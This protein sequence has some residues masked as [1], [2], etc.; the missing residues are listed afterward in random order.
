MLQK[1]IKLIAIVI[2]YI[3]SLRFLLYFIKLLS[4]YTINCLYGQE[5]VNVGENTKFAT[6]VIIRSPKRIFIGSNCYF[7]HNTML[8]AGKTSSRIII[9]NNVLT[10]PN[11]IIYSYNHSFDNLNILIKDQ[12]YKEKDVIIESNVWIGAN[13]IILPGSI[14]KS[15]SI[16]GAGSI[17]TGV[18]PKNSINVGYKAK[19]IKYRDTRDE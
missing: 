9:G 14:I 19:P 5:K 11:V 12:G 8:S 15:G 1:K 4:F 2:Y 10:G 18:I 3:I 13:S 17:I 6:T 16:I 7:N